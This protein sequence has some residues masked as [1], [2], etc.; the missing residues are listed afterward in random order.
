MQGL[1]FY[2]I[3]LGCAIDVVFSRAVVNQSLEVSVLDIRSGTFR[4][5]GFAQALAQ[6]LTINLII[7]KYVPIPPETDV[8]H[9]QLASLHFAVLL[10]YSLGVFSS[11]EVPIDYCKCHVIL[12]EVWLPIHGALDEFSCFHVIFLKQQSL[13]QDN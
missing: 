2:C 12:A 7:L 1:S 9:G 8:L 10:C 11:P 6:S 4:E 13:S 3:D 5:T